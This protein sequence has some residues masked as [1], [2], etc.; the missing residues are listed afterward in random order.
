MLEIERR[1]E[2]IKR[3]GACIKK[4]GEN[5]KEK[6]MKPISGIIPREER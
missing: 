5:E 4:I 2:N 6:I 1:S 3:N